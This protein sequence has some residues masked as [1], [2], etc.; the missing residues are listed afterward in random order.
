MA[1]V[2]FSM[3]GAESGDAAILDFPDTIPP[4]IGI[5]ILLVEMDMARCTHTMKAKLADGRS[6]CCDCGKIF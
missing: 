5:S 2:M 3:R 4:E 1:R 6:Y